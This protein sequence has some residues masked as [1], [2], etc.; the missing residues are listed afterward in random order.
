MANE[1]KN[2][3][4]ISSTLKNELKEELLNLSD[5]TSVPITRLL[6]QAVELLL[7]EKGKRD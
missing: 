7:K 6:D 3:S 5:E 1:L 4:K 2:R